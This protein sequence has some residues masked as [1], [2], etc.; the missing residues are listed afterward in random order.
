M[1]SDRMLIVRDA[2][3]ELFTESELSIAHSF[4][5]AKRRD[6]WLLSRGAA[7]Q[8]A[9]RLGLASDPRKVRVERPAL[10][11]DGVPTEWYVSLSHSPPYAAAAIDRQPV[12]IDI[13]I[14]REFAE[15]AAHLFLS[16]EETE[17]MRGCT[18]AHRV[19]HFWCAKEAAWKQRSS[20]LTT[21]KQLPIR[22]VSASESGLIFDVV[23]TTAMGDLLV[24]LTRPI[25]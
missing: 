1:N 23:E 19:L 21:M 13:Q 11:I 14:V 6:E 18:L 25:S 20:E 5:L 7:K 9:L 8:L 24:A 12:G 3:R 10:V 22:L 15:A 4:K 2:P 16:D 17:A